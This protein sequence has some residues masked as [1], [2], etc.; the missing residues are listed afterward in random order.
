MNNARL[1][2]LREYAKDALFVSKDISV[3]I[4]KTT[5]TALTALSSQM[6]SALEK[7]CQELEAVKRQRDLRRATRKSTRRR[8]TKL[9]QL[10]FEEDYPDWF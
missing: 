2:F 7:S 8:T 6:T 9:S 1:N 4:A 10:D 5:V 3:N